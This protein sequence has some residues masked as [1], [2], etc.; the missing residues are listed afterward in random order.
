VIVLTP[1]IVPLLLKT[2]LF[3]VVFRWR[4]QKVSLLTSFL[5]AGAPLILSVIPLPLPGAITVVAGI[6]V[7]L[8]ILS[9]YTEVKLVPEGVVT[10][11][12]VEIISRVT[13]ALL[14]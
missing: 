10:V 14:F 11:I 8:Y 3:V 5:L 6:G 9:Q 1:L 2:V 7:A 13:M 12:G 4:K